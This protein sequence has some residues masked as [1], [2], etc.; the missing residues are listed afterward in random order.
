MLFLLTDSPQKLNFKK[1]NGTLLIIFYVGPS[2]P[3]PQRIPFLLKTH[4]KN[5]LLQVAGG[6]TPIIVLKRMLGHFVKIPPLKNI[7]EF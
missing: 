4:T 7:L 5:I 6:N 1:V 2:S 3:Q